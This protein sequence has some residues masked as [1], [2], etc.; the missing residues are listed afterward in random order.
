MTAGY[1][2]PVAWTL[3][4]RICEHGCCPPSVCEDI[5]DCDVHGLAYTTEEIAAFYDSYDSRKGGAA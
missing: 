5:R 3:T 4:G 1:R 2:P